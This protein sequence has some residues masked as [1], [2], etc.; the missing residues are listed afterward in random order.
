MVSLRVCT[1]CVLPETFP[2]IRFNKDGVCN[3]C[4]E[5]KGM[6][7]IEELQAKY[8]LKFEQLV[9]EHRNMSSY[10]VLMCYSGGKDSTYTMTILKEKYTLNI[11]AITYDNGFIAPQAYK[12][13]QIVVE[14]LGIDHIFFKPRFDMLSNLFRHCAEND[15]FSIKSLERASTIC[16]T[17]MAIVKFHALRL[18]I[19]KDIPFIVFGW[20][21]GQAPIS[22]SIMKNNSNM[23]KVMQKTTFNPLYQVVGN[24]IR[25][26]FLEDGHFSDPDR[27]PYNIHPLAFLGYN[28]GEIYRNVARL[29]WKTPKSVDINSTNCMLNSYANVVHKRRLHF[30][31]YALELSNLVRQGCLD[32][33]VALDRIQQKEDPQVIRMVMEKLGIKR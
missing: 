22:S 1:N 11:L 30:H 4:L 13:I 6:E 14:K 27:F 8:K 3:F 29:G 28:E 12:N 23:V 16:T 17:C 10:D 7:N 31:P 9:V 19:E 20:S 25:P 2:G 32:R 5:S 21:P 15:L 33:S 18:A 26:Y 24:D